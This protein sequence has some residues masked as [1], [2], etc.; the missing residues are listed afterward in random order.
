MVIA[1]MILAVFGEAENCSFEEK[2]W[3]ACV[4]LNRVLSEKFKFNP[5]EKDFQ[6][7]KR[8]MIISNEIERQAFKEVVKAC[9]EA[10]NDRMYFNWDDSKG[11]YFFVRKNL[12]S[13]KEFQKKLGIKHIIK[14]IEAPEWFKHD[15]YTIVEADR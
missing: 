10:C 8:K 6:G 12:Y 11:A 3:I 2:K 13:E 7:Y 9:I 14:K 15:F 4:I 1:E 5:I